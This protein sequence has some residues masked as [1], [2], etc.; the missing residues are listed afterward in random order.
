MKS[1]KLMTAGCDGNH[2]EKWKQT[3]EAEENKKKT[4]INSHERK[5]GFG[6]LGYYG[7]NT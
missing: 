6:V 4:L 5:R 3:G 7:G 1:Q 2:G